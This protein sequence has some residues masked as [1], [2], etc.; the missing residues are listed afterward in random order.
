MRDLLG[1]LDGFLAK[2]GVA[3]LITI[4]SVQGSSPREPGAQMAVRADGRFAGTIGGGVLEWQALGEAQKMLGHASA[5]VLEK[6]F[7]LG[8]DLGQCCGGRVLLRFE[9]LAASD[10]ARLSSL[11]QRS[12]RMPVLIFGAGHVG[13]ALVLALAPLPFDVRWVDPRRSEFPSAFPDNVTPIA[14]PDP[15]DEILRAAPGTAV[16]IFTHSHALDL[17]LCHAALRR[18][19]LASIGVIGSETKRTRFVSQLL[20]GG[21]PAERIGRLTCPIGLP[22][23]GSKEPAVIAAGIVVQLLREKAQR[24]ASDQ[25]SRG[26]RNAG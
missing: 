25:S 17:A 18:D 4:A 22:D 20:K 6:T 15:L 24:S 13:R 21:L 9:R 2:D 19:D 10:R 26:E 3:V 11:V 1:H 7:L 5:R 23:L 14:S 8:P 12:D 16:L